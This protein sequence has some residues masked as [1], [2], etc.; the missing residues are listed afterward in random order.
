VLCKAKLDADGIPVK[1]AN[2]RFIKDDLIGY[3]VTERGN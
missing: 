2:G 3:A 1:D